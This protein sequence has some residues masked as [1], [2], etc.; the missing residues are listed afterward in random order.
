VT[1]FSV[2]LTLYGMAFGTVLLTCMITDMTLVHLLS[3]TY[4]FLFPELYFG[5]KDASE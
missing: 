1:S 3:D 5:N 4:R 2:T